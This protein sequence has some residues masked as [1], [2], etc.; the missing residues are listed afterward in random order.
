LSAQTSLGYF[1]ERNFLS[2]IRDARAVKDADD[3]L[4]ETD[5]DKERIE[6]PGQTQNAFPPH[7]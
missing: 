6:N 3:M 5:G 4:D 1:T 2:A 7:S